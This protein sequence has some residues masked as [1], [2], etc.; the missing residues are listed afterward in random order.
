M[1]YYEIGAR[2]IKKTRADLLVE[3]GNV[4]VD[5][6]LCLLDNRVRADLLSLSGHGLG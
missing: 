3:L 4:V 5:F 6:C 1:T 2:V